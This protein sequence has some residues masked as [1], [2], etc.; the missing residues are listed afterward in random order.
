MRANSSKRLEESGDIEAI[1]KLF[2]EEATLSNPV[3]SGEGKGSD[4]LKANR[5][6]RLSQRADLSDRDMLRLEGIGQRA[7]QLIRTEI[8]NGAAGVAGGTGADVGAERSGQ[9]AP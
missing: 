7:L 4:R 9:S 3:L 1:L 8:A 5:I 2:R 6:R